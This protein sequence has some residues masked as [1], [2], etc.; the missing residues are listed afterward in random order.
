MIMLITLTIDLP[1]SSQSTLLPLRS[2]VALW[3]QSGN[4][5][6]HGLIK[7]YSAVPLSQAVWNSSGSCNSLRLHLLWRLLVKASAP[8]LVMDG[9]PNSDSF[10]R[11]V[12]WFNALASS[13]APCWPMLFPWSHSSSMTLFIQ[14][15]L[16]SI[17]MVASSILHLSR[18]SAFNEVHLA[19]EMREKNVY[20]AY[21]SSYLF[22]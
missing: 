1:K 4:H 8:K 2:T 18:C 5:F 10:N 3:I 17:E 13:V 11:L 9:H 6:R 15:S 19:V 22:P 16:A 20:F 7:A 12:L 21:I 14:R